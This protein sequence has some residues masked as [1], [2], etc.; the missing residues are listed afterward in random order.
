MDMTS[1]TTCA[2][3]RAWALK[4]TCA[5]CW[6]EHTRK[7]CVSCW[8]LLPI[9]APT[10][11]NVSNQPWQAKK[12]LLPGS[13][14]KPSRSVKVFMTCRKCPASTWSWAAPRGRTCWRLPATGCALGRTDFD[15]TMPMDLRGSFGWNSS[16]PAR[17]STQ[18][19]G[20]LARLSR[21][22]MSRLA[23]P[24]ACT[25]RSTS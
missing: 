13:N 19:A 7:D 16:K 24:E 6:I 15:W 20:P 22:Q 4:L 12:A 8:I 9:I 1:A 21:R 10:N 2:S 25:A 18:I 17:K 3:N 14:G 23:L 11:T 5:N